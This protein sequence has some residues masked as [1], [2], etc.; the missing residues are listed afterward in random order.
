MTLFIVP[1]PSA[2]TPNAANSA[3]VIACEVSTLPATTA[4]GW[5]GASIE[6]SGTTIRNGRRQPSLSGMSSA[7]RVR[8]T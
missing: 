6:P 5:V 3:P 7:T 4:A 1:D 8:N 2:C